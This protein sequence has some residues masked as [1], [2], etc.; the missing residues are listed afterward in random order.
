MWEWQSLLQTS[1]LCVVSGRMELLRSF[2]LPIRSNEGENID[3]DDA[4]V[5]PIRSNEGG[6]IDDDDVMFY[7][8]VPMKNAVMSLSC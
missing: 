1:H 6:N 2:V 7:L 5:L 4:N 3:Y 8:Y